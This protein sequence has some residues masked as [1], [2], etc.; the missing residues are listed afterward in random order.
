QGSDRTHRAYLSSLHRGA[1]G[2][3]PDEKDYRA[4]PRQMYLSTAYSRDA[5]ENS[6]TTADRASMIGYCAMSWSADQYSSSVPTDAMATGIVRR[7]T[8]SA[9]P[10]KVSIAGMAT[11]KSPRSGSI[12]ASANQPK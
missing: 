8:M 4:R 2:A 5:R 6:R 10:R 11:P 3:C 1:S 7:P 9:I 12:T